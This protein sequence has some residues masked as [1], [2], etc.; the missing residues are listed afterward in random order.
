M[1]GF[2]DSLFPGGEGAIADLFW[3]SSSSGGTSG[4]SSSTSSSIYSFE[5][6]DGAD[7]VD[8]Y[9][10]QKRHPYYKDF[11]VY[12]NGGDDN[13]AASI[14]TGSR[15]DYLSGGAGNDF[16]SGAAGLGS[17]A[18]VVISGGL[19]TD[20]FFAAGSKITKDPQFSRVGN[21]ITTFTVGYEGES[22]SLEVA[23][24]DDVESLAF[25]DSQNVPIYY[26]TE[27]LAKGIT[28]RVDFDELYVRT[29]GEN[30]DWYLKGLDTSRSPGEATSSPLPTD[31][32]SP[33]VI[34]A[35]PPT[36][37]SSISA[38]SP[39]NTTSSI[40]STTGTTSEAPLPSSSTLPI[41]PSPKVESPILG[42]QSQTTITT[43]RL[44][45]PLTLGNLQVMQA[46]VGTPQRDYITGGDEGEA[47]AGGE[48]KD[49]M[50]GG[51]G[52]DA[53]IFE[54]AGEFGKQNA[55]VITD[56]NADQGDRIV[57]A[58]EAFDGATKIRFKSVTGKK[59]VRRVTKSNTNFIY[60]DKTGMLYYDANGKKNGFGPGGEF[61]QLLGA[62]EIGKTDLVIV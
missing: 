44:T 18:A 28:R 45:I 2:W 6:T 13:L 49:R 51:G 15:V 14:F 55:D 33:V 11:H 20:E 59:E 32:F 12:G 31:S 4:S 8:T 27:D 53:F 21:T 35:S 48:G 52:P 62:P 24:S 29:Y 22:S 60:D 46:V 1:A 7:K 37:A 50:T 61:T 38:G 47:L 16:M 25:M 26:L 30:A 58:S 42:I 40:P 10:L 3:G 39:G 41:S 5:G 57:I 43:I 19:G 23:V 54:T 9:D 56:F 17:K 36:T 34:G